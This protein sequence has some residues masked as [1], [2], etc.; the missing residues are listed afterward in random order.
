[1]GFAIV[2]FWVLQLWYFRLWYLVACYGLLNFPA[3]AFP[4]WRWRQHFSP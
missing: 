1:L 2:V 4:P 3:E